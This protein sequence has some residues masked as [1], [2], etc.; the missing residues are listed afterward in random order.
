MLGPDR[1]RQRVRLDERGTVVAVES[2]VDAAFGDLPNA[3]VPIGPTGMTLPVA[4]R[5]AHASPGARML[6]RLTSRP[7]VY[8]ARESR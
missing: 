5:C 6:G 3:K 2:E 1:L 8:A 7:L 4:E